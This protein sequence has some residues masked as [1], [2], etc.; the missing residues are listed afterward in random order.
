MGMMF[1]KDETLKCIQPITL[2]GPQGEALCLGHKFSKRF[3]IAGVYLQ[4][5]GYVLG[6]QQDT[7]RFFPLTEPYKAELQASGVLPTPLP[8]YS[9]PTIEYVFGYSLWLVIVFVAAFMVLENRMKKKRRAAEAA[10]PI[11]YGPPAIV[12]EADAWLD[13]Q[14]RPLLR[15]DER[16]QHQ[17][18]TLPASAASGAIMTSATY[19]VLTDQRLFLFATRVGAFG[20]LLETS[21]L[22]I[23]D[24]GNVADVVVDDDFVVIVLLHDKTTRSLW[25]APTKKLS[26]QA[27]LGRDMPRILAKRLAGA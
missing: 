3:F 13:A 25:A 8:A 17:A 15:Q 9:I 12:T 1:G 4:D 22:E 11:G 7:S 10:M 6:L 19:A 24:L 23:I 26:N 5:E 27:E 21:D 20:P 18:Y 16:V 14:V 2:K